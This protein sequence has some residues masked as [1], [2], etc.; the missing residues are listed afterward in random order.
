MTVRDIFE[1]LNSLYPVN[2]ACDFDNVG[3]LVGDS[4]AEVKKALVTLDC[5]LSAVEKAKEESCQLIIT[6]HPVIFSPLKSVVKGSLTYE[7]IESKISVISMHTNLDIAD[8]GVNDCL[9]NALELKNIT[10]VIA[11][12][13][14]ILKGGEVEPASA[15][16]FAKKI[17]TALGGMVKY[18]DSRKPIERV[19]V[20]S[21]SGGDFIETALEKGYDALVT[22]DVK[23][24]QFLNAADNSV[25]I[26]DAGHF[27]TEDIVI[28]P[29][30]N[31]LSEQF[32]ETE[33]S[34]FHNSYI[35]YV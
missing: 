20:C 22:A 7:L 18:A 25:S 33:F 23:H 31:I 27:E 12:D 21:G 14:F 3:I 28:N 32:P 9:F 5:T 2:T 26:F 15:D 16:A 4:N 29:L 35:K 1:F 13:G 8:G 30:K 34:A 11:N 19:L 17:K 10:P 6:H 24:H